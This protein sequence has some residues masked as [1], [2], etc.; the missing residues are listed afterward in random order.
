MATLYR[1]F[2]HLAPDCILTL[3]LRFVGCSVRDY[4]QWYGRTIARRSLVELIAPIGKG[5]RG[6]IVAP[7]KTGKTILL[8][9]LA[10]A[11]H[12]SE[13]ETRIIVLLIDERPEEVTHF[14]RSVGAEVL[15][16][17]NDQTLESHTNLAEL[18]MAHIRTELECG[19]NIVLLMDSITRL[20]RAFNLHGSGAGR[21]MTGGLD[22]K[23]LDVP[24]RFFG[25][26][27]NIEKG[28]SVTVIATALVQTG[29][30]MDDFIF[31]EF[32]STGNSELVLDRPL[33]EARVFPAIN[34]LATGTRREELLYT[35]EQMEK[36]AIVRRWI[37]ARDSKTAM[38]GLLELLKKAPSNDEF[39]RRIKSKK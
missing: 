3:P 33:A 2:W 9:Q 31:E 19:R 15:A 1:Y 4:D 18:T 11:I 36:L 5:T 16:S 10:Q 35:P 39:L 26:A 25:L 27:R 8:E 21:T 23:A 22:A 32:K 12:A 30:R 28:G 17:S 37:A 29:S 20:S 6:L 13:P 7:P 34:L 24:R 38:T 14:R